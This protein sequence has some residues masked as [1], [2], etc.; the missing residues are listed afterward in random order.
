MT[1]GRRNRIGFICAFLLILGV[2]CGSQPIVELQETFVVA[3]NGL[4][5]LRYDLSK[6]TFSLSQAD[7]P[8]PVLK[9]AVSHVGTIHSSR[10]SA[11][12][13]WSAVKINDPL[14]EGVRLDVTSRWPDQPALIQSFCVYARQTFLKLRC[15]VQ[16][17]DEKPIRVKSLEPISKA[18]AFDGFDVQENF[19]TLDGYCGWEETEV[20]RGAVLRCRNNLLAMFGNTSNRRCAVMGG[21]TYEDFEK[22]V[23]VERK[24]K[25]LLVQLSAE[26]P[27]GKRVDPGVRYLPND[28]FYVDVITTDPFE[29]LEQ[30]ARRLQKAQQIRLNFYT[31][32][33]VCLWYARGTGAK[34]TSVGAVEQ[35]E[36][37]AKSGFLKFSPVAVRLVPDCYNEN[38]QQGWWDDA[39]WQRDCIPEGTVFTEESQG[40]GKY[41][42]PYET[43]EKWAS[44]V[45]QLGCIPFTY[46]QPGIRSQDYADAFP[47]HMLFNH[48]R[49]P[50]LTAKGQIFH[51]KKEIDPNQSLIAWKAGRVVLESYDYTDPGFQAHMMEV[52]ENLKRSGVVGIMYDYPNNAWMHNG[53][54]EDKYATT[55]SAY[56]MI[57]RLAKMGLGEQSYIHER[58]L[59]Y[60]SDV[61]LG[62]VDSQRIWGD[63]N[64]LTPK[65]VARAALRWYKNRVVTQYD[66][67]SKSLVH[68]H[69]NN[70]DGVRAM[71]TMSYVVSGRLLLGNSFHSMTPEHIYDL[72]RVFPFHTRQQTA[73]PVDMFVNPTPQIYDFKVNP[74]WH[75][76]TLYNP[77]PDHTKEI[78]V[79]LSGDMVEGALGLEPSETY[80]FY[81]FWNDCL[82]AKQKADKPLVQQLRPGEARMLSVRKVKPYPQ[83]L[84]SNRH[85]MQGMLELSQTQ[86]VGS[87][88]MLSGLATCVSDD[89]FRIVVATNGKMFR[90]CVV[91]QNNASLNVSIQ[92]Q[93]DDLIALEWT[94]PVSG[95]VF[96]AVFFE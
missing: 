3:K 51:Y 10:P 92:R 8:S 67:D 32:P 57:Y 20:R 24:E 91:Q 22:F 47:E 13:V 33:T 21:L 82:Q 34:N 65:M 17:T 31:F 78:S 93:K 76:I 35:A 30:Y 70:R 6:G 45:R 87:A 75:Q 72:S 60:G 52:Y 50:M 18:D 71:L 74:D 41:L 86:W 63:T 56:R 61:A 7:N 44:A 58:N 39:H 84:S 36:V 16:N 46:M 54:F 77:D 96:W 85:I 80:Y 9:N 1:Y 11:H 26:D 95:E 23:R 49:A 2:C 81:D 55:A 14:G 12:R 15:G 37:I 27:Q 43:T 28:W 62:L 64:E 68:A 73:R 59:H 94:A 5:E 53:G 79:N 88:K 69:P 19:L 48:P 25:S 42:P 29:S 40:F 4:I 66:N 89:P 38:N 90:Q 83:I